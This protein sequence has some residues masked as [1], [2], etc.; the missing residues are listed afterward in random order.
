MNGEEDQML[1]QTPEGGQILGEGKIMPIDGKL[2][3]EQ[4]A[5][6]RFW[7]YV[8]GGALLVAAV[9]LAV[10]TA[11]IWITGLVVV[12]GLAFI[13]EGE[14]DENGKRQSVATQLWDSTET[15]AQ[16]TANVVSWI[17]DATKSTWFWLVIV[18]IAIWYFTRGNSDETL[19]QE[20]SRKIKS[21]VN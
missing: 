19:A 13:F 8:I 7:D 9:V 5:D 11:P 1:N 12:I 6:S 16:N 4:E 15:I 14:P 10:Y 17:A 2:A 20:L 18:A 21:I 3:A